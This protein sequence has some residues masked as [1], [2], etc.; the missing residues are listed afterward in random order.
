MIPEQDLN[1]AASKMYN[2]DAAY[3]VISN[4]LTRGIISDEY[5]IF[6]ARLS[7]YR[8]TLVSDLTH[9]FGHLPLKD[10]QKQL[11]T[12]DGSSYKYLLLKDVIKQTAINNLHKG[13]K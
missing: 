10:L 4:M 7:D 8:L 11:E 2:I 6:S 5:A 13:H 1:S 9:E 3:S 12:Y